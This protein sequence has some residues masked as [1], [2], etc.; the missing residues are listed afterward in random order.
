[1]CLAPGSP[2]LAVIDPKGVTV[3]IKTWVSR[4]AMIFAL[5]A[6]LAGVGALPAAARP[7]DGRG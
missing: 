1:M 2:S 3:M 4:F 7:H 5:S 6:A